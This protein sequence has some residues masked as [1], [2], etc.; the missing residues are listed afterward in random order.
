MKRNI[1]RVVCILTAISVIAV[2]V[3]GISDVGELLRIGINFFMFVIPASAA[4][5]LLLYAAAILAARLLRFPAGKLLK[6]VCTCFPLPVSIAC[7]VL[8][9]IGLIPGDLAFSCFLLS[10]PLALLFWWRK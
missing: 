3:G 10:V 5:L 4:V 2:H 7:M 9:K 8:V 1:A 6:F